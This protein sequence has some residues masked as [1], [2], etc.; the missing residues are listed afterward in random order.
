MTRR[1]AL[2]LLPL[3]LGCGWSAAD[4]PWNERP[5]TDE[6]AVASTE[7]VV[8][9]PDGVRGAPGLVVS[10]RD[11]LE[12]E[13]IREITDPWGVY[14]AL[15]LGPGRYTV[16]VGEGV[17]TALGIAILAPDQPAPSPL[18]LDRSRPQ[19]LVLRTEL[20]SATDLIADRLDGLGLEHVHDG[21]TDAS[22]AGQLL[23][24]PAGLVDYGVLAI[25]GE[26]DF[27]ALAA[28]PGALDG[29]LEFLGRGGGLYLS[30]EA[31]PVL[32]L[33]APG[34]VAP[35]ESSATGYVQADVVN[36]VLADELQWDRVGVRLHSGS[37]LFEQ[38]GPDV[39][40]LLRGLVTT[41]AG[42]QYDAPLLLRTEVNGGAVVLST[43]LAPG[44]RS[45][46]WW[47]GDP[48]EHMLPDGSWDGRGAVLDRLILQL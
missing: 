5:P 33:L 12:E 17:F 11:A 1:F 9:A 47:I 2:T 18:C 28:E 44:P 38:P 10:W 20:A 32:E 19:A 6:P 7:G 31:W 26:L 40:V 3:F 25:A 34:R 37:V 23:G 13:V 41:A 22:D 39:D 36:A 16:Q 43:F 27:Q 24:S 14:Q 15:D 30:G 8:C 4:G 35:A 46:D 48:A 45:G 29:L 21:P 42:E